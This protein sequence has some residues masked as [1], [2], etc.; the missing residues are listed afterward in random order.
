MPKE[1]SWKKKKHGH[2]FYV[3]HSNYENKTKYWKVKELFFPTHLM[4]IKE[5]YLAKNRDH[6]AQ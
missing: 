1:Y 5:T 2:V 4:S 3:L 6:P